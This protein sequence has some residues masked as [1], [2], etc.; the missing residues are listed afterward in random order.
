MS[1]HLDPNTKRYFAQIKYRD[2]NGKVHAKK[3]RGFKTKR[4]A[5]AWE[6]ETKDKLSRSV[7]DFQKLAITYFDTLEVSRATRDLRDK[8]LEKY[9]FD[10]LNMDVRD[11][12]KP[13]MTQWRTWLSKQNISSTTKNNI[14]TLCK[15]IFKFGFQAYGLPDP[16]VI[17]RP[18]KK[19]P[20]EVHQ[21][22]IWTIDEFNTFISAIKS[23]V[24]HALFRLLFWTGMRRGEALALLKSDLH[25]DRTVSINKSFRRRI[26]GVG[27]TKNSSSVRT[28]KI[29][30]TT[31][32]ELIKICEMVDGSYI[33][34][35]FQPLSTQAVS[36][37]FN[38]AIT[39]SGVKRIR[40]HDLR[41]S[42]A[43]ILLNDQTIS[44]AA[45]SRRLGHSN[46][47]TTMATYTHVI[48]KATHELNSKIVDLA[49]KDNNKK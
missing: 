41:H 23:P 7:F 17:L 10:L 4:E 29:D 47:S 49:N 6:H 33:F 48:D 40:I 13:I 15:S 32:Q 12:S 42:H 34:G 8:R 37:V 44:V 21:M 35:G 5:H 18:F 1:V 38:V 9:M 31:Y 25:N 14:L 46:V 39:K 30:E 2:Q 16:A 28:I 3:K 43:S 19:K 22:Q 24:Y 26:D 20:E 11:I 27:A 45:V 36:D